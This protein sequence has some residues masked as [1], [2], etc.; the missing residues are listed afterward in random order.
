M[1]L[2]SILL[3]VIACAAIAVAVLHFRKSSKPAPG[4]TPAAAVATSGLAQAADDY[5]QAWTDL[6]MFSGVVLLARDGKILF[7]KAYGKADHSADIANTL[8]TKFRIGS[9]TKAFTA[10]AV[11]QLE[12]RG[13]LSVKSTLSTYVPDYPRG[14]E[15]T[16]EMLLNHRSGIVDH[17]TLPDFLTTRR[18][19]VCPL[20]ETI[21]TFK[22]RPWE[23]SPGTRFKYSSSGYILLGYIIEKVTQKPY[24]EIVDSQIL[25]P[26]GMSQTGFEYHQRKPEGMALGYRLENSRVARANDRVMQNAHASGALFSTAHDLYLWD[27]ALYKDKLANKAVLA[28]ILNPPHP[29]YS[30]GW[31]V[32]RT[33]DKKVLAH[34]G[35][36]EGFLACIM[37]FV[38]DDACLIVL[39]NFEHCPIGRIVQDLA[40]ILFGQPY[41]LPEK[42]VVTQEVISNYDAYVGQYQVSPQLVLSITKEGE[43]LF[44]QATGQA[45][46]ELH[47]RSPTEFFLRE[48]EASITFIRDSRGR[49]AQLML[50]Q[51]G[52]N[53]PAVRQ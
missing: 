51:G 40:A 11:L 29:E 52:K 49:V 4:D 1:K 50:Q 37:R 43:K 27:R 53:V 48:V 41:D 22:H 45:R 10:M 30:Y 7:H 24:A 28:K 25:E 20:E 39:S 14:N 36:T 32:T 15:I 35:E 2:A 5:M 19:N 13:S 9:L 38:D 17:T 3:L 12:Q 33:F 44:C 26:L 8:D 18:T 42:A 47:P 6:N 34:S 46:L 31:A 16:L 23:F 21:R